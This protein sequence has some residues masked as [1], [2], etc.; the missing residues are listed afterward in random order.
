MANPSVTRDGGVSSWCV[1]H[2]KFPAGQ[3]TAHG[4]GNQSED[5]QH[6]SDIFA[7]IVVRLGADSPADSKASPGA[8][9]S[10]TKRES[11][12]S[13]APGPCAIGLQIVVLLQASMPENVSV[14]ES[15]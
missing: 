9:W 14:P 3:S 12:N 6:N 5:S 8:L 4:S 1:V 10:V 7:C 13:V 15:T 2:D 11:L